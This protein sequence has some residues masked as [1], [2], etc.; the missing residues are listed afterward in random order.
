MSEN[1]CYIK[2]KFSD[3]QLSSIRQLYFKYF[4]SKIN[5]SYNGKGFVFTWEDNIFW[6]RGVGLDLNHSNPGYSVHEC[7]TDSLWDNFSN[8]LPYMSKTCVVT[9]MPSGKG[10]YPHVD[11]KWRPEAIYIP[12]SGCSDQCVSKIY[13][14]PLPD[15]Q[16]S[17]HIKYYP[18]N[19]LYQYAIVDQPY[20]TNTHIWHSVQNFS[21]QE[22]ITFGWN[23]TLDKYYSYD[24]CVEILEKLGY[25]EHF[26]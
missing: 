9:K 16:N 22:R 2:L 20:L 17:T 13:D 21:N 6:E 14:I 1:D 4:D 24:D 12:I 26:I 23:F 8:L 5:E 3:V 25:I 19:F 15:S 11:R 7:V 18:E 10:M